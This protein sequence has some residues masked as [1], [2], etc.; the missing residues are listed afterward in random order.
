AG[1]TAGA[2]T[3]AWL[4]RV[5][6]GLPKGMVVLPDLAISIGDAEWDMLGPHAPDPAGRRRRNLETHPQFHLK[7]LLERM[8]VHRSEFDP[9]R[10]A[11]EHDA[12]PSRS[13]A[14]ASAMQ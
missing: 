12:A 3:I 6:A 1:I 11:S 7:L 2:P 13:K 9:W 8:G 4:Q 14:I 10:A 5:V